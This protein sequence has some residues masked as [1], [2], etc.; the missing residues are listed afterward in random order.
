MKILM[1]A[2]WYATK[3]NALLGSFFKE[4]AEGLVKMGHEVALVHVS[5]SD[6][7][8]DFFG[9]IEMSE[10]GGVKI[11]TCTKTNKTPK[12]EKGRCIQRTAMLKK[13]YKRVLSKFGVPDIVNLRSSLHGYEALALCKK[14]GLPL[15]FM[16]HSSFVMTENA[17]SPAIR[18]LRDVM[19]YGEVNACVSSALAGIMAPFGEVRVIPDAVDEHKF[20]P[21]AAADT[22]HTSG[23]VTFHAMGQLRPIKDYGILIDAFAM[24]VQKTG[25]TAARLNI[26]GMGGLKDSLQQK[27]AGYGLEKQCRLVGAIPRDETPMF[28]NKCDVFICSSTTETLSCVLNEAA[29]CGKPLISTDCGGPRDIITPQNGLLVPVHDV[30]AMCGAM[31][32]MAGEYKNYNPDVIRSQTIEKFGAKTVYAQL[33]KAC[34]DTLKGART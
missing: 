25:D 31:I 18:R 5:V 9:K 12:L 16:E 1:I 8:S 32:Q 15:F 11:F 22:R 7:F 23:G 3:Q 14:Y 33:E 29:C 2:S 34:A 20:V 30:E 19:E 17:G 26:A 4:Q 28:M 21:L 6:D 13:I 10:S 24:Y 27:I